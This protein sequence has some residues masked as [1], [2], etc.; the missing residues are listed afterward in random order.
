M[1][2]DGPFTESK[3]L[4]GTQACID[5][6]VHVTHVDHVVKIAAFF[7]PELLGEAAHRKLVEA[8]E[9]AVEARTHVE[10]MDP[11]SLNLHGLT[12]ARSHDPIANLGIHPCQ[13]IALLACCE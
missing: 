9:L 11:Q 12:A 4:I 3:E 6:A 13:L 10:G 2:I 7:A 1:V 8:N 5:A